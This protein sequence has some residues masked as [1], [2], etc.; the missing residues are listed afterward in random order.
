MEN[1]VNERIVR[2]TP[3]VFF[4]KRYSMVELIGKNNTR[5]GYKLIPES[6]NNPPEYFK[7]EKNE[8]L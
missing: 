3:R 2:G 1:I 5:L 8:V 6:S 4:K 7:Y